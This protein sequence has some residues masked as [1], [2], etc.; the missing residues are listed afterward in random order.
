MTLRIGIDVG[1]TFTDVTAFDDAAGDVVVR[2]YLSNPAEPARVMDTI[3]R[4]LAAEYGGEA[5]SLVLHGSTAALNTLLEGKGVRTGL[6]TTRGFRDV[7]E[8]GRQWRG[9]EVFNIFPPPPKMLLPRDRIHEVGERMDA[10]GEIVAALD[11]DDVVR[12]IRA[13][14][15]QDV[16]AVAVCFLFS[17]AN[18]V[19]EQA[20]AAIIAEVAP[21]LY[22]SLSSE[23]N[24]EWR[25]YERTASAVANAYIGPP[26]AR[27]LGELESL[28][29][30]RFP[31]SRTLMMKSDG[32]ASSAAMLTRTPIQTVMS[33]PV[34]GVIG[35]RHLGDVKA[36]ENLITFDAGGTSSDMAVLPGR[37]LFKSELAVARH[38]L[39]TYTV[40]IETIGAGGGSIAAV[41]LGGVLKVGPDSAG[42]AP[43]PACYDRGGV[44]PTLTDALVVLGHLSPAALLDGAMPIAS[45]KAHEA[46]MARVARPLGMSA[47]EAADGILTV[48]ATNVMAAM[49]TITIERGYDPREFTLLPFGGM[50]PT[51]AG[52]VAAELGIA[53]ILIPRDP[54]TFSAYGMLVTDVHQ[55]RSITR[56]TR[57]EEVTPAALDGFF[58]EM[59]E[60]ALA[61]LIKEDFP[62]ESLRSLRTAGM[63]YRGQSYEVSV[64]VED[65]Q[66]ADDIAALAQVFHEAHRRRYGHMAKNEAV[67]IV[68]F[69]VTAMAT[70][71]RPP[72]RRFP[73]RSGPPPAA[74]ATRLACFASADPIATP[75]FRRDELAPGAVVEGPAI[76]EEK[77]STTVLYPGQTARIDEYLNL[78]VALT[79]S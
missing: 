78:E 45:A 33:G 18:P 36:I 38:P 72:T 31:R 6:L 5:V 22:V 47:V 41:Q 24:P 13:L 27:Y 79:P 9:D 55:T 29:T 28:C 37:P 23:V 17:Y 65:V 57:L 66:R 68:N 25:E 71:P 10:R 60:G 69:Q 16:N 2:K 67:E 61:E 7:Y 40:D 53:R 70:I 1:G 49:R 19:H 77:T 12:A 3:T 39:R 8:I 64:P 73:F 59:E 26:V 4:D 54:G 34:A 51:I 50:G 42:A 35:S 44:E 48:L 58:R 62:R 43:G 32:G 11:R 20:A 63:R 52:R 21:E 56:V 75:V 74:H 30:R 46:V 15:A 14:Q 76:I